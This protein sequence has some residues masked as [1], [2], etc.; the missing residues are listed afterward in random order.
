MFVN[1][2]NHPSAF[3]SEDQR[4]EAEKWG[5]IVDLP[6]PKVPAEADEE[7]VRLLAEDV[8]AKILALHPCAVLCQGEF[9]L[10]YAI[11]SSLMSKGIR[12]VSACSE[13]DVKEEKMPDGSERKTAWF[14]F[15]RFRAYKAE[16][17]AVQTNGLQ[18]GCRTQFFR[19]RMG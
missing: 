11:V 19:G 13:R 4:K 1:C 18:A 2:S 8:S 17:R 16:E 5:K 14:R 10:T 7:Q 6:F 12:V 3:W 15:V 9:T